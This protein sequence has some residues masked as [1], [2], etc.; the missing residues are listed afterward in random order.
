MP[1]ELRLQYQYFT[2]AKMAKLHINFPEIKFMKLEEAVD[3]YVKN[4]LVKNAL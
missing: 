4:Y 3:D 2:E 1:L